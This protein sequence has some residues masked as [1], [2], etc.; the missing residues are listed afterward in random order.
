VEVHYVEVHAWRAR[1]RLP[2]DAEYHLTSILF[3][4]DSAIECLTFALNALGWAVAPSDF[5]DVTDPKSL[6][7]ISPAD[8]VGGLI[9]ATGTQPQPGFA[10]VFPRIQALWQGQVP[11]LARIRDLHDVSKHRQTIF[12]GGKA[13]SDP[14]EGFFEA[15]GF[16][17]DVNRRAILSPMAEIILKSDPKVPA[18]QRIPKGASESQLLEDLVPSFA[19]LMNRSGQAALEDATV[20]VP[21]N[22]GQFRTR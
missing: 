17:D 10:R 4:M 16:A 14:P 6:R 8:V 1:V 11:L 22:E 7:S 18:I 13:R 5:R 15:L 3:Q 12:V 2:T 20:N 21:L 19:S 9:G